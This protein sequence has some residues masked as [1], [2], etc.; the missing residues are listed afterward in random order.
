MN[1]FLYLI[2]LLLL[3]V[4]ALGQS[5]ATLDGSYISNMRSSPN[6][7]VNPNCQKN[8]YAVVSAAGSTISRSTTTPIAAGTECNVADANAWEARWGVRTVDA[9]MSNRLCEVGMTLRGA[10]SGTTTLQVLDNTTPVFTQTVTLDATNPK[11]IGGTFPCGATLNQFS[12]LL[13]GTGAI[14]QTIE[15][16][17]VYLGEPVS[18]SSGTISTEWQSYTP[19]GSW[20]ANTTYTGKWRRVGDTLEAN[21]FVSLSGAPTATQ[22]TVGIPSGLTIDTSKFGTTVS[23]DRNIVGYGKGLDSG[24]ANLGGFVLSYFNTTSVGV[25]YLSS[26]SAAASVVNA[27]APVTWA[28]GDNL[29]VTFRVPISGWAA[30]DIVTPESSISGQARY[31]TNA[32]ATI[33]GSLAV[34]DFE[35]KDYD[36]NGE[37]TSG[38]DWKFT[39]KTAGYYQVNAKLGLNTTTGFEA[40]GYFRMLLYKNTSNTSEILSKAVDTSGVGQY[41]HINMSDVVYLAVGDYLQIKASQTSGENQTLI[42]GGANNFISISKVTGP[43]SQSF[44]LSSPL[45][46]P[47]D[48]T[49]IKLKSSTNVDLMT[50]N[51]TT[52]AA[53]IGASSGATGGHSVRANTTI[54]FAVKNNDTAANSFIQFANGTGTLGY[55][56]FNPSTGYRIIASNGSTDWGGSGT[57]G[58]WTFGAT[59]GTETHNF[60]GSIKPTVGYKG[61]NTGTAIPAGYVGESACRVS[62][63]STTTTLGTAEA[64]VAGLTCTLNKG[65][66]I[67]GYSITVTLTTGATS[68]NILF[69][70]TKITNSSNTE[71]VSSAR[72]SALKTVAAVAN[73]SYG[74]HSFTDTIQIAS[75][76]TVVKVRAF[77]TDGA[78]TNIA[79]ILNAGGSYSNFYAIRLD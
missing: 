3:P 76:S 4:L 79:E 1:R 18:V 21:V 45:V 8:T 57:S 12:V 62:P 22:L 29:D 38:A 69:A 44:Y 19:T 42:A 20:V 15:A 32:G 68:G 55:L 5:T 2:T 74:V 65:T 7:V 59:G 70:T 61:T 35:D 52:G 39:A 31:S 46:A 14:T 6:F 16:G 24:T 71:L 41:M 77:R 75:D 73:E 11:R 34:V 40:G 64:D 13:S 37:V 27:T 43:G 10:A 26:T 72:R 50:I 33:T 56:G 78:G 66:Y 53:I 25:L 17:N 36:I 49:G 9:G 67:I 60:N 47:P 58:N 51:D 54:P 63:S 48:G 23:Q 28:T 30:T